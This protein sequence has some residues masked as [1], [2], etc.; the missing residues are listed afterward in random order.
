MYWTRGANEEGDYIVMCE[1]AA[2][3]ACQMVN[4]KAGN[5]IGVTGTTFV[6]KGKK[7]IIAESLTFVSTEKKT[8]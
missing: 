7:A 2:D 5:V 6:E 1:E 4:V 3:C 8:A